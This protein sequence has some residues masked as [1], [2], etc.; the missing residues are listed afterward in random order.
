MAPTFMPKIMNKRHLCTKRAAP[1]QVCIERRS[2]LKNEFFNRFLSHKREWLIV[3][4]WIFLF[5]VL[6]S[7]FVVRRSSFVVLWS[8]FV[9]RWFIH[10]CHLKS[11][12]FFSYIIS[13]FSTFFAHFFLFFQFTLDTSKVIEI[14]IHKGAEIHTKNEH[15]AEPLHLA[16]IW[17][18]LSLINQSSIFISLN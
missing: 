17:S 8:L 11:I 14:L 6:W 1:Q 10:I 2:Q 4:R 5:V 7:L 18:N 12:D 13:S 9:V 15:G 16:A 3:L